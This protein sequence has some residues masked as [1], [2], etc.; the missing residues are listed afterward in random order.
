LERWYSGK[1]Q[2]ETFE[3]SLA[4]VRSIES[5]LCRRRERKIILV[6]HGWFLRLLE[7]YFVQGKRSIKEITI[8]DMLAVD[9]VPLGHNFMVP[10]ERKF[11]IEP[12]SLEGCEIVGA[13]TAEYV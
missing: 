4:R 7:V 2:K 3:E 11:H 12:Q 6:T 10:V 8:N 9:P 1:N 5:F 13:K